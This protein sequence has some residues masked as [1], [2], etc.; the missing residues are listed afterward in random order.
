MTLAELESEQSAMLI[1]PGSDV[2]GQGKNVEAVEKA[3]QFLD[4][5]VPVAAICGAIAGLAPGGIL[6]ERWHIGKRI[7]GNKL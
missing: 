4:A 2:W 3:R 7:A 5:G 6:D 1:L